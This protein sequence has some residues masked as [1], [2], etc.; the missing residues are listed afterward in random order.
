M[1]KCFNILLIH[2]DQHRFDCVGANGHGLIR[3]PNLD[4]LARGGTNFT[5]AFTPNPVCSPARAC[6]QTGAWSST[7]GCISIY[8][9]EGF[10]PADATLPVLT[11]LLAQAGYRVGHIGKFHQE[12]PGTPSDHGAE[13]Y[14]PSHAYRSWRKQ[15]GL[16]PAPERC[17][18][19]GETD[20]HISPE[21]SS[22]AWQ[23]DQALA[24]LDR[25]A[26]TADRKP[27]LLRWDPPEPHL[28]NRVPEPFASMYPLEQIEPWPGFPDALVN[29]PPA[30]QR[31]RQRWGTGEW[32]WDHWRPI[33]QRYL[34]EITLLDLQIGRLLDRLDQL[35][36]A[37]N[38]L[39]V[40]TTD[41]GDMCG[42]HGMMDKH[43]SAYDDIMRVPLI[44]RWP[45]VLTPGQRC[46]AFTI[47]ELDLARTILAAADIEPPESFVGLNLADLAAGREQRTDVFAQYHGTH[48]S[49]YSLRMLRD[50]RWKYVYHP[51]GVDELY[52]MA[53]DPGE[54]VNCI[55]AP[56]HQQQLQQ[57]RLRMTEWMEQIHD[58][59]SPPTFLWGR[60][61]LPEEHPA[62]AR[63]SAAP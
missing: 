41:H 37:E 29:K 34:G 39:V 35:G 1:R 61:A 8:G 56:G 52:D 19:F 30:Q 63:P 51:A 11:A 32:T 53:A 3:T 60:S 28:P 42:G 10:R 9:T 14:V 31:S 55:D 23:C 7:H 50:R 48:Q 38:T 5:H 49:L 27:F 58:R 15:A 4:R 17:G 62:F 21:Q 45:G 22:L 26:T 36:L 18:L 57:M 25:F 20:P 44:V 6:L 12:V 59:L 13:V 16:P 47:H 2:S 40:Y 24:C 54:R 33:V 43:Y 46:D